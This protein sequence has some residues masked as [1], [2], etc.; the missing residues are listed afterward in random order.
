MA[1][2]LEIVPLLSLGGLCWERSIHVWAV[3]MGK[4]SHHADH[5]SV[6]FSAWSH[7]AEIRKHH[8]AFTHPEKGG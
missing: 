5:L 2:A 8:V 4:P 3:E 7:S 6:A 1:K